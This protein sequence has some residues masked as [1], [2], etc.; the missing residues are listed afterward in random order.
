MR[1]GP[2]RPLSV[3]C[4]RGRCDSAPFRGRY[5][6]AR[7]NSTCSPGMRDVAEAVQQESGQRLESGL[8]GDFDAVLGFEVANAG[9][10]I[11]FHFARFGKRPA[12]AP[13]LFSSYSSWMGPTICSS[14]SSTVSS[15]A[16]VPNSS[17]TMAMWERPCWNSASI[18]PTGLV[19]GTTRCLR[20]RRRMRNARLGRPT[21]M[22]S[23][24]SSQ[25]GSRSL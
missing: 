9:G 17:T 6:A 15:P 14:T 7:R 23:R 20:S 13:R 10:A 16:M 11:E 19:S 5:S 8:G 4:A 22:A 25:T 3:R 12:G 24:R 18:W 21:R 2:A 1:A